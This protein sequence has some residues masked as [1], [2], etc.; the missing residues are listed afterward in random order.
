M[1]AFWQPQVYPHIRY[2]LVCP[3]PSRN[4]LEWGDLKL[5]SSRIAAF[6]GGRF[7]LGRIWQLFVNIHSQPCQLNQN[8]EFI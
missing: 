6:R 4:S 8:Q 5:L 7:I 1:V 2:P 3:V